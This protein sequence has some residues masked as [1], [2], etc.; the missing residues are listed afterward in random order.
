MKRYQELWRRI[1]AETLS[2]RTGRKVEES[3]I[4]SELPPRP[5][6]GDL[7]FP[8]FPFAKL[9]RRS[10]KDVALELAAAVRERAAEGRGQAEAAGPYLNVRLERPRVVAEVLEEVLAQGAGYGNGGLNA[11]KRIIVEFSSPNTN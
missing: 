2:A 11:G 4:V 7:A 1:L 3:E 6:L 10:P 8:L 9:L 5:E